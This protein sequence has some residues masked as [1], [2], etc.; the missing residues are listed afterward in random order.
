MK[1]CF[2]IHKDV[3]CKT[4]KFFE[5]ACNGPFKEADGVVE[6]L[7]QDADVFKYFIYWLYTGKIRGYYYPDSLKPTIKD[8]KI[9]VN[10][11]LKVQK[12]AK[13]EELEL[14]NP[15]GLALNLANY[16][17]VPFHTAITLYILADFLQ[18]RGLK[19]H[20]ITTLVDVYGYTS[21]VRAGTCLLFWSLVTE[22]VTQKPEWCVGPAK[23]INLAWRMLPRGCNLRRLLIVLFCD[24]AL[25]FKF[26]GGE[27]SFDH[28]FQEE[29][30]AVMAG[31]WYDDRGTSRW[32]D[33]DVCKFHDHD[34]DCPLAPNSMKK[35]DDMPD[36]PDHEC[37]Y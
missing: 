33:G 21:D 17:D 19:D 36:L 26:R 2:Q 34:V 25:N 27:E 11:E 35:G 10:E 15:R 5:L 20:V 29:A 7:E 8:L 14:S 1:Q 18:V 32:S 28:V 9:L 6:L 30:F 31:R 24:N 3:L 12:I 22:G 13:L 23:G 4:S 16:R 37:L